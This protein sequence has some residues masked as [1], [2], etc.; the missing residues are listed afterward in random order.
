MNKKKV[1]K[2]LILL[3]LDPFTVILGA[4]LFDEIKQIWIALSVAVISCVPFFMTFDKKEVSAE[5]L[6]VLAVMVALSVAGRF[7]FSFV[8]HFKPITALVIITGMYLG[9]ESGFLCGAL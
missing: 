7:A 2:Y 3:F 4:F 6:V 9:A 5:R 1:I 8:P